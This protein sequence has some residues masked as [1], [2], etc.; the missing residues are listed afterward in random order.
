MGVLGF[1]FEAA[2]AG[3]T[4]KAATL[5]NPIEALVNHVSNVGNPTAAPAQRLG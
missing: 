3:T 2:A 5:D 1:A 4:M